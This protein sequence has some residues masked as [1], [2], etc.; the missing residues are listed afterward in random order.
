MLLHQTQWNIIVA[1][2]SMCGVEKWLDSGYVLKISRKWFFGGLDMGCDGKK[3]LEI[4][5]G[6]LIE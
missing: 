1:L 2:I 5:L 4:D 3:S 6:I